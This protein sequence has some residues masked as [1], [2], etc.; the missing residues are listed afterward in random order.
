MNASF[1]D[2]RTLGVG[3]MTIHKWPKSKRKHL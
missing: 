3:Y 1:H 2:E